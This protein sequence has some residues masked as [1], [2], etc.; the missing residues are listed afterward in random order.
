[1]KKTNVMRILEKAG[2]GYEP[3][4]YE[5][6]EDDLSGVHAAEQIT[7]ITP[8]QCFKTL[9]AHGERRGP[10]VFVLPV[11]MELDLKAAAAAA[12]DK[13]V[14]LIHV[15]ELPGLTGYLRGGCSPVGMKKSF[16]TYIDESAL[17]FDKIGVSAGAR[18]QQVILDPRALGELIGAQFCPM[19]A[20]HV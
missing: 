17:E 1:M 10:L 2:I 9:V 16:P 6:S 11:A 20:G 3:V 14:E 7:Q 12:G 5:Y 4:E 18:G 8:A 15:R 19:T 13:R